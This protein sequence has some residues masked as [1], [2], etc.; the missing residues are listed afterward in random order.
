MPGQL[1]RGFHARSNPAGTFR[2]DWFVHK[3]LAAVDMESSLAFRRTPVKTPFILSFSSKR[4]FLYY[5]I[6]Y[7]LSI[8]IV[9]VKLFL[10]STPA[11][12]RPKFA[13]V[14]REA[15]KTAHVFHASPLLYDFC[16]H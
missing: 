8:I 10:S 13:G 11:R 2:N 1:A 16:L 12:R 6:L 7:L 5:N 14:G 15:I 4:W 3:R 9:Q